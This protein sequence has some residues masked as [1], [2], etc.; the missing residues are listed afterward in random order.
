MQDKHLCCPPYLF[1]A[2]PPLFKF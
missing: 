2:S 1:H